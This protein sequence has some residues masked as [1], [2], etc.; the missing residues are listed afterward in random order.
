MD[1]GGGGPQLQPR[2]S[3]RGRRRRG[4]RPAGARRRRRQRR[5]FGELDERANR[6]AEPPSRRRRRPRRQGRHLR[7]EPR[8]VGRGVARRLQGARR[9]D[10][11]QL[12]LRRR[13]ARAT[14]ST[15][16]TSR[17]SSFERSFCPGRARSRPSSRG[18]GTSSCSRTVAT[19]PY[20]RRDPSAT[21]AGGAD[22]AGGDRSADDLY[23]LYTGGT[24]GMPKGVMWRHEDIFF[25]AMGG[26]GF[27]QPPIETPEELAQRIAARRRPHGLDGHR[28]D[29]ARRRP[30][31]HVHHALRRRQ[32]R[33]YTA[34][35]FDPH[36]VWRHRRA[37][38]VHDGHGRRRRHGPP[39]GRGA[40]PT[41]DVVRHCRRCSSIGSGG[42]VFSPAVKETAPGAA[43]ERDHR[44]TRRRVR[45]RR[46]RLRSTPPSSR[47]PLRRPA[48]S[49]P[50]SA[51]TSARSSRARAWSA[52]SP[53]AVTSRSG[54][55][56]TRRRRRRRS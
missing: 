30:V 27:G 13:R 25:A 18:S 42:A 37:R 5:T 41:R 29:H 47:S 45:G 34:H 15:T 35:D 53:A 55:T 54:T 40:R 11:H 31:G 50:S 32:G 44:S 52:G 12:P 48:T 4:A 26:G 51:T 2:R 10:Q 22:A 17:R 8:R 23:M 20:E 39:A 24:T 14:C 1:C 3:L 38:A 49:T 43:P 56:R 7:L 16:P 28:A 46:Q 6:L 36:E 9:P 19:R 21:A 33:A